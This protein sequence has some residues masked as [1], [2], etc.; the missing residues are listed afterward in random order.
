MDTD[1]THKKIPTKTTHTIAR[2]EKVY[3]MFVR[4]ATQDLS[5][6]HLGGMVNESPSPYAIVNAFKKREAEYSK[7]TSRLYKA[8][9]T[10]FLKNYGTPE[11][12]MAIGRLNDSFDWLEDEDRINAINESDKHKAFVNEKRK[13]REIAIS[14]GEIKPNTSGQKAKNISKKDLQKLLMSLSVSKSKWSIATRIWMA[15]G[16]MTGLRPIEWGTARIEF[17]DNEKWVVVQNAKNTNGRA[18]GK[19]RRIKLTKL[20]Q[21]EFDLIVV[22][23]GLATE[24]F[25]AGSWDEYYDGCRFFLH[26]TC[27]R[28]WPQRKH[29][30]TLYTARHMFSANAKAVFGKTEVAALMGHASDMTAIRNY[31]KR[32]SAHGGLNVEP[33][34]EDVAKVVALNDNKNHLVGFSSAFTKDDS[35]NK[36]VF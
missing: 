14:K 26:Q 16:Y 6:N 17:K 31:A 35:K 11:C 21:D 8:A 20:L 29:N 25:N 33:S 9:I 10:H 23:I 12:Y 28:L 34:E 18:T 5:S 27:M 3:T 30:P 19:E 2:Y 7:S 32:R 24:A 36:G 13:N 1:E 15:A 22:Q 4:L